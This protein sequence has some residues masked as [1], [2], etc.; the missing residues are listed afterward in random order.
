[1]TNR[2]K[3]IDIARG[4]AIICIIIGH[5]GIEKINR[6]VFTFHVPIFFFITGYFIN[7]KR[8]IKEF[9]VNK[10]KTL[11]IPYVCTCFVIIVLSVLIGIVRHGSSVAVSSGLQWIYASI[12]GAGDSYT[13]PF[14]IKGIG[15]LWFLLASF[16]GSVF[17]RIT[18]NTKK[19]V[20]IT[21]ILIL[22]VIGYCTP[23]ILFWF[24]FSIQAGC[25]ATLFMYIGYLVHQ[26]KHVIEKMPIEATYMTIIFAF[27]IWLSFIHNFKSF[28]L[29]HCDIGRGIIDIIGCVCA[30]YIILWISRII[31]KQMISVAGIL[32]YLGKYSLIVLSIHIIE[33]NLFP[34]SKLSAFLISFGFTEII[35]L[36]IMGLI[37]LLVDISVV[38]I[39]CK[40]RVVKKIFGLTNK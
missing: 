27:M 1:M 19:E 9:V 21:I 30:S 35:A 29:V 32:S 39:V 28:W 25:C 36:G 14:Y 26:S 3:Y 16:W 17:L 4:I 10:I 38:L 12:Y 6:I 7:R 22:F 37:K 2:M 34:W 40:I 15:A 13:E 23:K 20:R 5:L 24:P 8:T 18:L 11:L 33:L 31:E